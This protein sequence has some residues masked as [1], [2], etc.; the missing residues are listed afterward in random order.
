MDFDD[1]L[2]LK[3]KDACQLLGGQTA[4]ADIAGIE[5]SNLGKWLTGKPTLSSANV[6]I[7]LET[8]GLPN[9]KPADNRVH[10]W[11][12]KG[13]FLENLTN[14]LS[15]F[16]PDGAKMARAPWV[17]QK[18][19]MNAAFRDLPPLYAITDGKIRAILRTPPQ[20]LLED[21]DVSPLV[22]W[23]AGQD[24]SVIGID[25]YPFPKQWTSGVPDIDQFDKAW[26]SGKS[27]NKVIEFFIFGILQDTLEFCTIRVK[28]PDSLEALKAGL[29]EGGN[30]FDPICIFP[31]NDKE[32]FE[33]FVKSY[34]EIS[35]IL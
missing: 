21:K 3:L 9:G 1:T 29:Q 30:D 20:I 27:V 35:G 32:K 34:K 4:V 2:R 17:N 14:T 12:V 28:A 24:D 10:C 22:H 23:K 19:N 25:R 16:F 5:K 26:S 15:L 11:N 33:R 8:L 13:S 7:L 31:Q 18:Q 6:E